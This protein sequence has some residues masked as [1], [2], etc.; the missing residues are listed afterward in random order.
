MTL[1]DADIII[2]SRKFLLLLS[3]D[4]GGAKAIT[5]QQNNNDATAPNTP[6]DFHLCD[7]TMLALLM[8]VI[9]RSI[10]CEDESDYS[11]VLNYLLE[12]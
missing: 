10:S 6:N 8:F 4:G 5:E 7:D 9:Y 1:V 12:K 11:A 3:R 2:S